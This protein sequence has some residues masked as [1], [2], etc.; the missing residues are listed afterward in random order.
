MDP[1]LLEEQVQEG[2]MTIVTN[3]HRELCALCKAGGVAIES[4]KFMECVQI[5]LHKTRQITELV[6]AAIASVAKES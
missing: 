2:S 3:I 1:S 5:A 4:A 6:H